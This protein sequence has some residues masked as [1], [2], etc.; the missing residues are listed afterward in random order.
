VATQPKL[1]FVDLWDAMLTSDGQPRE[2]LWVEDRIHPNRAG[3]QIRVR[4][5]RPLL[6]EPK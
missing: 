6:G 5:T 1:H 3:Y 4:L 2:D